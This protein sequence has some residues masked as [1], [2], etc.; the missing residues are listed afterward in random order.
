MFIGQHSHSLD[1]KGRVNIPAT[2]RKVIQGMG[3]DRI[4]L[5]RSKDLCLMGYTVQA[6]EKL[7]DEYSQKASLDPE[8]EAFE[9]IYAANASLTQLD[10]QGRILVPQYLREY[11]SLEK[12]VI[13]AGRLS[14]F[15]LWHPDLWKDAI[16]KATHILAQGHGKAVHG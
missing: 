12:E 10:S 8:L 1:D 4:I 3:D 11:A 14:K 16:T 9:R 5:T 6:W 2:F 7:L 15:E 13:F